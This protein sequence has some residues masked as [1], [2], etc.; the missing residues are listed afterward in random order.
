MSKIYFV[1]VGMDGPIKIGFA[2]T[3]AAKRIRALM[4]ISPHT[5]R[6]IGVFEGPTT[7][8][9][10]AHELLKDSWLRGEWFNPTAQVLEFIAQKSPGFEPVVF[11]RRPLF[12]R[13]Q[14]KNAPA[15]PIYNRRERV[16][17]PPGPVAK[18][19]DWLDREGLTV[20]EFARRMGYPQ[21]T[22][23]RYVSGQRIPEKKAMLKIMELT[24][25]EVMPDDFYGLVA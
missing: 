1:Q 7:D 17:A 16:Y 24:G 13:P 8:E 9:R 19:R 6:W 12:G 25:E 2:K 21:P 23:A 18:F 15:R 14:P 5:L 22:V 11:E 4:T 10:H 20:S 3:D